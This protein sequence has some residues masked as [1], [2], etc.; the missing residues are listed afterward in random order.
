MTAKRKT[1]KKRAVRLPSSDSRIPT[2]MTAVVKTKAVA[3]PAGTEVRSVPVPRPGPGEVLI[4]V[5]ATAICGSDRHI[6]KW[7]EAM[8]SIVKPPRIYGHEFCG[9]I[10][11]F[12]KDAERQDLRLGLYVSAEMHVTCG[13]CRPC[14]TGQR[15]VCENT[16]ILGVHGDGC[17]AQYVVVPAY[18]VIPLDRH[19][20]PPRVGAFLD[21]L[22][23][24]VHT[25]QVTDLSGKSVAVLGYGPIGAMCA[26]IARIS[27]AARIA[28]TE[29]NAQAAAHA[30]R[31]ASARRL[32]NVSVV[33]LKRTKDPAGSVRDA[34]GGGADVVLELSGAEAS[35]NLGLEVARR[36]A[37]VSLLGLPKDRS[38][39]IR[40]YTHSLIFK[41]L[42]LHAVIGRRIFETWIKMLDLLRAGLDVE[43]IV[44]DEFE[45]L[46]SFHDAMKLLER[47]RAMKV[48]FYPNGRP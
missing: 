33:D 9:E 29:V 14:R 11:R 44:T 43:D 7:D 15:H 4:R 37:T 26:E 1:A 3:G 18:N 19:V 6:Y 31:W 22:G 27:G 35:I 32:E 21:A 38:V 45:G 25:A 13:H 23:N 42:T 47:R 8:A 2:R 36:G 34:L 28:I 10:V 30:R 41:G 40:D 12:G 24:A 16:R 5:L 20:V 48:V 17:F 46:E 39:T